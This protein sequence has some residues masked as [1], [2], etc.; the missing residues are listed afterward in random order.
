MHRDEID[1]LG[2]APSK[3]IGFAQ[4][5]DFVAMELLHLLLDKFESVLIRNL[6]RFFSHLSQ[7]G[8]NNAVLTKKNPEEGTSARIAACADIRN[9][10]SV[11][12]AVN[13]S[14]NK[15]IRLL[16]LLEE[17]YKRLFQ[18]QLSEASLQRVLEEE[19]CVLIFFHPLL[20][21]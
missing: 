8:E 19:W 12:A 16:L 6:N 10:A 1:P 20:F 21:E 15:S 2:R 4:G 11:L 13:S 18:Q 5:I 17:A 9:M 3:S 14:A 7:M